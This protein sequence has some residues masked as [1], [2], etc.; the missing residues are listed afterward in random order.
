M[1]SV[2]ISAALVIVGIS[3]MILAGVAGTISSE[4]VYASIACVGAGALIYF[5]AGILGL[6]GRG[7]GEG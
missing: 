2:T 4:I 5:G 6:S 3:L 7:S 1:S